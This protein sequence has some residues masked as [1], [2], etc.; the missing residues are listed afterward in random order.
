MKK[1]L[2][3]IKIKELAGIIGEQLKSHA[4]NAVLTGG[5]CVTVFSK[6]RYQSKDLDFVSGAVDL[7]PKDLLRAMEEI[8]FE[9]ATDGYFEKEDCPFIVEF[10]RLPLA[11]GGQPVKE[12]KTLKTI[13]GSFK[14][15]S[16]TD[17]VKDRLAH[18]LFWD[19]PQGLEQAKMVASK[20]KINW[21]EVS[22]WA[23][24]ENRLKKFNSIADQFKK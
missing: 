4:I 14:I 6:N 23:R 12:V 3:H 15:L 24:A 16:P 17:C 10:I 7:N 13:Y 11:I 2:R 5:A 8:G 9:K 20:H 22:K 18:Y 1:S 19:D 21:K